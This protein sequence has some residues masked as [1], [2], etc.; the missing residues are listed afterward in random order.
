[1]LAG[2]VLIL[3]VSVH[4]FGGLFGGIRIEYTDFPLPADWHA[5]LSSLLRG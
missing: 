5:R 1:M 3:L 2:G 4:G